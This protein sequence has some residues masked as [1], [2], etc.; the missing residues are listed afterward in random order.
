M[1]QLY[2]DKWKSSGA[3]RICTNT[4][5]LKSG[6]QSINVDLSGH[7][8]IGSGLSFPLCTFH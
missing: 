2:L 4:R 7:R 1:Q 6:I 3:Y 8:K 5:I